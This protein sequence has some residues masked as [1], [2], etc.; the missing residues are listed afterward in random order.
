VFLPLLATLETSDGSAVLDAYLPLCDTVGAE[1]RADLSG[2]AVT[3]IATGVD[4]SG[5]LILDTGAVLRSGDVVHLVPSL[6]A[7]R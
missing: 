6:P 1:V 7:R 5:A 2:L 3:G 4:P